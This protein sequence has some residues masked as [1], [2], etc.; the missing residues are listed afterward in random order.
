MTSPGQ[1][2]A[3]QILVDQLRQW[4]LE[5]LTADVDRLIREG[6][7]ASAVTLQLAETTA[8]KQRFAGNELRRQKGLPVLSPAEYVATE[9]AYK[10]VLRTFG[11][12]SGFYDQASDFNNFIGA[13]VSPDEL[14]E[15]ARIA[16]E[17]FLGADPATRDV[18]Q[19]FYGLSGGA[20]IAAVL[21][22]ERALPILQRQADAAR[23]GVVAEQQGLIAARERLERY[24][25]LGIADSSITSAFG[26]IA[27]TRG[28][29]DR[30]GKRFGADLG[31]AN[32][33]AEE[34]LADGN[35]ARQRQR[36]YDNESALF[37]GRAGAEEGS[38]SRTRSG[39]Y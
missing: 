25:D 14:N 1:T 19:R 31:Q 13:D 23:F 17:T 12:P 15:R 39:R 24:S 16:Q 4:G 37:Q 7:D 18:W 11:L 2:S 33:E 34:L 3:R 38:L 30:L 22:P 9:A 35:A 32:R 8:Y 21:D 26:R 20:A 10:S 6:L 28:A 29:D 27:A 5:E 36:V